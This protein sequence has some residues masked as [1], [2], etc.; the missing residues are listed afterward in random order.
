MKRG[1][2]WL[3]CKKR[4]SGKKLLLILIRRR[5]L[6][7]KTIHSQRGMGTGI[8]DIEC[9]KARIG[10]SPPVQFSDPTEGHALRPKRHVQ[11]TR[12]RPR[13]AGGSV[14]TQDPARCPSH[15]TPTEGSRP[16]PGLPS[17]AAS[18]VRANSG[19][20]ARSRTLRPK[21]LP[22]VWPWRSGRSA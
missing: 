16:R 5:K 7:T 4:R 9:A 15:N 14:Q 8:C 13:T 22:S 1:S 20:C 17:P 12:L 21:P 19:F 2:R 3:T 6:E 11:G 18:P 10:R